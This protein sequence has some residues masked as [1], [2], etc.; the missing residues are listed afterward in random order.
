M[1]TE[2]RRKQTWKSRCRMLNAE[3]LVI[4]GGTVRNKERPG[5]YFDHSNLVCCGNF[6]ILNL[7]DRGVNQTI[8]SPY[9]NWVI[10]LTVHWLSGRVWPFY[11]A[12]NT[13][14]HTVAS[15]STCTFGLFDLIRRRKLVVGFQLWWWLP[16]HRIIC[17]CTVN[18]YTFRGAARCRDV[19]FICI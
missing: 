14:V 8:S 17:K 11:I 7:A 16:L 13:T 12:S 4:K 2:C 18:T 15:R 19:C 3:L 10:G 1:H 9:C 6:W 5:T